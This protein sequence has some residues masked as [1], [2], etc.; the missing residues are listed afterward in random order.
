MLCAALTLSAGI[1]GCSSDETSSSAPSSTSSTG[2]ATTSPASVDYAG[3]IIKP[4]D[5]DAG[6]T[7]KTTKPTQ[8]GIIGIFGNSEETEKITSS[9]V[10]RENSETAAAAVAAAKN[11][12]VQKSGAA[13]SPSDV[14]VDGGLLNAPDGATVVAFHEGKA[15]AIL[16]FNSK[17]GERVPADVAIEI[18]KKQDAAIKAGLK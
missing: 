18:A 7:L 10:V 13:F 4:S 9:V 1:A 6:W 8:N 11:A 15:F 5:I 14:G 16:E 2:V 12:V 3:L 17:T